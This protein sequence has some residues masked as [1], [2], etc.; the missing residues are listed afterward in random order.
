MG[1][2]YSKMA[3]LGSRM[4]CNSFVGHFWKFP[5]IGQIWTS[6][7]LFVCRNASGNIKKDGAS[8]KNNVF[9]YLKMVETQ[10]MTFLEK[11]GTDK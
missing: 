7:L 11:P 10:K 8:I 4:D 9:P 3:N 1:F 6:L 5:K 2:N